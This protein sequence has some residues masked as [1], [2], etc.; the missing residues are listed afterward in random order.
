MFEALG[1]PR[2]ALA[3]LRAATRLEPGHV[4]YA[5]DAGRLALEAGRAAE[6]VA[7][8]EH[9]LKLG[10]EPYPAR[11]LYG[12]ALLGAGQAAAAVA[13][14]S[15][16]AK[17]RDDGEAWTWLAAAQL[18]HH[19]AEAAARSA[20][21]ALERGATGARPHALRTRALFA[22]GAEP[23]PT[24]R[25]EWLAAAHPELFDARRAR[26][27]RAQEALALARQPKG[28][29]LDP[30]LLGELYRV[31][32]RLLEERG[33]GA[34]AAG[35]LAVAERHSPWSYRVA[36]AAGRLADQ[37]GDDE[38]A[39]RHLAAAIERAPGRTE[40]RHALA[41]LLLRRGQVS[42]A[43]A[44]LEAALK[45][46]PA[47][48]ATLVAQVRLLALREEV[49]VAV[50]ALKRR[51]KAL[52]ADARLELRGSRDFEVLWSDATFRDL[53]GDPLPGLRPRREPLADPAAGEERLDAI[54]GD[55]AYAA[56]GE[57]ID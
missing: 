17:A 49:S 1:D 38:A 9:A 44:Q 20:A 19:Q 54:L 41:R 32:A 13:Q 24:T 12:R 11:L 21:R 51:A 43:L 39:R 46:Q 45:A 55:G 18:A 27:T 4:G 25:R 14:L 6:A 53:V 7:Y 30:L 10:V 40:P 29:A 15:A 28:R 56:V 2:L 34:G 50:A 42:G 47:A 31:R 33:D 5:F 3:H 26:S 36:L 22:A 52:T 35:A 57:L 23:T 37:Q 48:T 8:L 16:L